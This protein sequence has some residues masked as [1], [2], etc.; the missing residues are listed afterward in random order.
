[1]LHAHALGAVQVV[2][3]TRV[4][5]GDAIRVARAGGHIDDNG[6]SV[7]DLCLVHISSVA[8]LGTHPRIAGHGTNACDR[9][10]QV[11][12]V[13]AIFDLVTGSVRETHSVT[14]TVLMHSTVV[15]GRA[16][17][18]FCFY[19]VTRLGTHARI[20]GRSAH[21]AD[22]HEGISH[23]ETIFVTVA[24]PAWETEP[25]SGAVI[26]TITVLVRGAGNPWCSFDWHFAARNAAREIFA[27]LSSD[28]L[29]PREGVVKDGTVVHDITGPVLAAVSVGVAVGFRFGTVVAGLA[30]E[31]SI[32]PARAIHLTATVVA[33]H[34]PHARGD[35]E[36]RVFIVETIIGDGTSP[37]R[38]A[39]SVRSAILTVSVIRTVG[40]CRTGHGRLFD[41]LGGSLGT[42]HATDSLLANCGTDTERNRIGT[43]GRIV[44]VRDLVTAANTEAEPP[45]GTV[46]FVGTIVRGFAR[47]LLRN[48]GSGYAKQ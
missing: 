18:R 43:I 37:N 17:W 3:G 47:D 6:R 31:E 32:G 8:G 28:A 11:F 12:H 42:V 21:A 19:I 30:H 26:T 36:P 35:R 45:R 48:Y 27:I 29:D 41:R 5:E 9:H 16:G 23:V 4:G 40:A 10:E 44:T 14:G 13:A 20:A 2:N 33:H 24:S 22:R 39:D 1:M 15:A 7:L 25:V 46:G 38:F 34:S